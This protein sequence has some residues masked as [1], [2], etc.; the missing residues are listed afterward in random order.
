MT[1]KLIW[2]LSVHFS[3]NKKVSPDFRAFLIEA[4]ALA[5]IGT[6]A[7]VVPLIDENRVLVHHGLKMLLLTRMPG[8]RA[9][10]EISRL[11]PSASEKGAKEKLTIS[12]GDVGFR[13]GPRI[14]AAG[15]C[16]SAADALEL[17]LTACPIRAGELA[18]K[19]E[20]FNSERQ[21]IEEG[22]IADARAQAQATLAS[23][24]NCRGFVLSSDGWHQG[25]IGIAA[26]R[27]VEEFYRPALLLAINKE[28]G[29]AHGSGRSIRNFNLHAAMHQ[30]SEHLVTFG[31]HAAAAGLTIRS[32]H[33][34]AFRIQFETTVFWTDRRGGSDSA[35]A[36]RRPR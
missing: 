5:A 23:R 3:Q 29:V 15:R 22:I 6:V 34:D 2:A 30:T 27:I 17:L 1:F 14:N 16:G 19:L 33:I 25:V 11:M 7:D 8:L 26:S 10:M 36:H 18:Q 24:P 31:G 20:A 28:S 32:E 9:L 4:M 35:Y 12:P 21:K 13:L